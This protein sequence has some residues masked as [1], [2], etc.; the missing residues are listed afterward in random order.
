MTTI[1][2][3]RPGWKDRAVCVGAEEPD[4]WFPDGI[5]GSAF[6]VQVAQAAA[7][8]H[9]QCPVRIDCLRAAMRNEEGLSAKYRFGVHGGLTGAQRAALEAHL[10]Q[11]SEQAAA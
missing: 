3:P 9:N 10:N 1:P 5:R 6:I 8:C 11:P 7:V 2:R 4:L